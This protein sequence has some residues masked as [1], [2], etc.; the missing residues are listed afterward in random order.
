MNWPHVHL[1]FHYIE[2]QLSC[3]PFFHLSV[4]FLCILVN[5]AH[6]VC[7]EQLGFHRHCIQ[8]MKVANAPDVA[9]PPKNVSPSHCL[10]LVWFSHCLKA[11]GHSYVIPYRLQSHRHVITRSKCKSGMLS[12]TN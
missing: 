11:S 6:T 1:S 9:E 8:N 5:T 4:R 12:W 2:G 10:V 3:L 7:P